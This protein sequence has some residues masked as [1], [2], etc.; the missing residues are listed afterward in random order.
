MKMLL[1]LMLKFVNDEDVKVF[2]II[3]GKAKPRS[4]W[5][6]MNEFASFAL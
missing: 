3:K 2:R 5:A 1:L 6:V 4:S